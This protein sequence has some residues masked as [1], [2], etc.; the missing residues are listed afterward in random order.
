M[1]IRIYFGSNTKETRPYHS[2]SKIIWKNVSNPIEQAS[3]KNVFLNVRIIHQLLANLLLFDIILGPSINGS[4]LEWITNFNFETDPILSYGLSI[5]G[6]YFF[7]L[8][9]KSSSRKRSI[10]VKI[11]ITIEQQMDS[12]VRVC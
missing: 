7:K 5:M 11:S 1:L 3:A 2:K 8:H 6:R 10:S 9:Q 12:K 4:E